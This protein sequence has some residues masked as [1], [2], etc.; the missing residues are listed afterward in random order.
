MQKWIKAQLWREWQYRSSSSDHVTWKYSLKHYC[1]LNKIQ[2]PYL[3]SRFST[4]WISF[5]PFTQTK[6]CLLKPPIF[7][8]LSISAN[9]PFPITMP[10]LPPPCSLVEA[11]LNYQSSAFSDIPNQTTTLCRS[12]NHS[13]LNQTGYHP[14]VLHSPVCKQARNYKS[15]FKFIHWDEYILWYS[16]QEE[17]ATKESFLS[18]LHSTWHF[19]PSSLLIL[20][21]LSLGYCT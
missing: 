15:T 9:V 13:T 3:S 16:P 21:L 7:W 12:K 1:L 17:P 18:I 19:L 20:Q 6:S 10:S 5:Y 2:T 14:S 8:H 4:L 11:L